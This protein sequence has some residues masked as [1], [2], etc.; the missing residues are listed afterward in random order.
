MNVLE[1]F[2]GSCLITRDSTSIDR[3]V[4]LHAREQRRASESSKIILNIRLF[5]II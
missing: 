2:D 5:N 1:F 4:I 3:F